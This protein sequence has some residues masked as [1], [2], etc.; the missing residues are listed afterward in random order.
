MAVC[1][2]EEESVTCTAKEKFPGCDGVPL[3]WAP[4]RFR[5]VGKEPE[6]TD[7]LYGAVPPLAVS[8]AE[9]AVSA[10]ADGIE[11]LV[12][13]RSAC[14]TCFTRPAHPPANG[15]IMRM[16]KRNVRPE[17]AFSD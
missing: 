2:G 7:Q 11:A 14:V 12:I 8:T 4:E 1:T 5:P 15:T 3:I 10:F 9:Y 16:R 17:F 13:E 6:T